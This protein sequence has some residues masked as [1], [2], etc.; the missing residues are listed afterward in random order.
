MFGNI[1]KAGSAIAIQISLRAFNKQRFS[2]N[3]RRERNKN[4]YNKNPEQKDYAVI[5][6]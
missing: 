2:K 5:T 4:C 3:I 6:T 1:T